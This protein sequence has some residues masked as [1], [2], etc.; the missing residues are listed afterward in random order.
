[1]MHT[2][3]IA[4]IILSA[5]LL[6]GCLEKNE[7]KLDMGCDA[8]GNEACSAACQSKFNSTAETWRCTGDWHVMCICSSYKD[9]DKFIA[10]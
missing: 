2:S 4:L 1:M 5:V 6:S 8:G 7:V 10:T 9:A 3:L